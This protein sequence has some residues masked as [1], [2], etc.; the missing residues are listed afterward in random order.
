MLGPCGCG[1]IVQILCDALM[2][3]WISAEQVRAA[4]HEIFECGAV[5]ALYRQAI[6]TKTTTIRC[7]LTWWCFA[8]TSHLYPELRCVV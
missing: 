4:Q 3:A 7:L 6:A 5:T 1:V 2:L 8:H